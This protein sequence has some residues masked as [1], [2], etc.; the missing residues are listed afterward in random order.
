[1]RSELAR[2]GEARSERYFAR[3]NTFF[4]NGR[5]RC[6]KIFFNRSAFTTAFAFAWFEIEK[7]TRYASRGS[8]RPSRQATRNGPPQNGAPRAGAV[9]ISLSPRTPHT[10][11]G[12]GSGECLVGGP[13]AA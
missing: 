11:A 13:R 8:H 3:A 5:M 7:R 12:R 10:L 4:G 1:M 9:A 6:P 2:E